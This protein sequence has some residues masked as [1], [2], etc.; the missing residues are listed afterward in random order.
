MIALLLA[1]A[2]KV[3]YPDVSTARPDEPVVQLRHA[4]VV[5]PI[6]VH[7][8]FVYWNGER[9]VRNE[10]FARSRVAGTRRVWEDRLGPDEAFPNTQRE[11]I[12]LLREW[13]GKPAARLIE[14]LET[15]VERYPRQ[16]RYVL[17][18]PNSNSY[19]AWVLRKARVGYDL[20]PRAVGSHHPPGVGL[21]DSRT[22]VAINMV[23]LGLELGAL[24]GIEIRLGPAA[25]GLDLVPP[26][27]ITPFGRLGVPNPHLRMG[28][29]AESLDVPT[30]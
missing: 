3:L 1:C 8:F 12:S 24:D 17:I 15:S 10:L 30:H 2:P 13:R 6:G 5:H 27:L 19:A 28:H 22:G 29:P 18:G 11:R 4:D 7:H 14:V 21:S 20:G 9:W 23:L 16:H 25:F 26:A